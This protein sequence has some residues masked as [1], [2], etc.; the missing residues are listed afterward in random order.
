M[1]KKILIIDDEPDFLETMSAIIKG[2]GF[3][4]IEARD[5][6][7]GVDAVR[8]KKP[9]IVILDYIMPVMDGI[10]TLKKIRGIDNKVPVIMF[11][12]HPEVKAIKGAEKLGVSAFIPKLCAFSDV[13]S[14]LRSAVEMISRRL[15]KKG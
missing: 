13:S 8:A 11:T 3:D 6:K 9:D 4:I 15:N 10:A 7:E 1:S 12:A 14:S 2:W 5:G